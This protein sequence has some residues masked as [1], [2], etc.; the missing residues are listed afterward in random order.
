MLLILY[1]VIGNWFKKKKNLF[2]ATFRDHSNGKLAS[3]NV[4]R[5]AAIVI[6]QFIFH[7][8]FQM[9]FKHFG[10]KMNSSP[11]RCTQA[12]LS[13]NLPGQK[14]G[15][16]WTVFMRERAVCNLGSN[17]WSSLQC[18]HITTPITMC[19]CVCVLLMEITCWIERAPYYPICLCPWRQN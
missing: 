10:R 2:F 6:Q 12:A 14:V 4:F 16:Y 5:P 15:Q 11:K 13:G 3:R 1:K 9:I 17:R 18:S 8:F 7:V 19:V